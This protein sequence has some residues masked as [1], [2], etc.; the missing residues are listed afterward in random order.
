MPLSEEARKELQEAIQI[1]RQDKF[2]LHVRNT[3]KGYARPQENPTPTPTPD[4]PNVPPKK[5]Q[6]DT[7]PPAKKS[8]GYW[9]ELLDD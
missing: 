1:V 9:G 7:P 5:D 4:D 6:P 2:E 3:L 8:G